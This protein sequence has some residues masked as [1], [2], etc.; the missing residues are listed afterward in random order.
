[1]A[2]IEA[3][4]AEGLRLLRAGEFSDAER[5][6]QRALGS[7]PARAEGWYLLGR[8]R[9]EL[10]KLEEAVQAYRRAVE[11]QPGL[12]EAHNNLGIVLKKLGRIGEALSSYR[13]AVR[14][15]P[16]YVEA[17]NNLGNALAQLDHHDE[18]IECFRHVIQSRPDYAEAHNNLGI[19]F[20]GQG[21]WGEA[22]VSLRQA[23][24]L[25]PDFA[26]AHTNLGI[27]LAERGEHD[28]ALA[29]YRQALA[30]NPRLEEALCGRGCL[31]GR[32]GELEEAEAI[33]REAIRL[34]P[35]SAELWGNHG[36]FLAEQG[37]ISEGLDSYREA[38]RLGPGSATIRSNHLFFL[39]Y[40]PGIDSAT[41]LAEHRHG[42]A[43]LVCCE[44]PESCEGRDRSV[45]RP[46]RVGY[47][48]P[49]LRKHAVASFLEPI[50]AN[51][52]RRRVEAISYADVGSPDAV[53]AR[54]RSL[55]HDWRE[56]RFLSDG[57]LENLIRR[58]R[59]DIL[60]D[61]AGH[62]ARNRLSVF[63]RK[64]APVQVTY[65]GYPTTT[66]LATFD[67]L[68]TDAVVDPP[69]GPA[70]STEEP[71]R[72]PGGSYCYAPPSDAPEV[73]PAPM[74]RAGF[75]TFGSLHKL[76]KLNP[77][78]LDLWSALLR[79]VPSAR[80]LL[81]RDTLKG[82]R[83]D[84]IV[85]NFEA[86]GIVPGR[87]EI[88]HDWRPDEHWATYSSIDVSLDVFPWCGHTTACESLWMGVPIVTLAGLRRSSRMTA[89]VLT[90]MGLTELIA[91]TSEQYIEAASRLV[92]DPN[93]LSR[94][95]GE[96]RQRMQASRLCDGPSFTRELEAAY[97]TLWR[98][99]CNRSR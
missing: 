68:L 8:A 61:L 28:Q 81:I 69:G 95:R 51:H 16:D 38:I 1:M 22:E 85:A 74:L 94:M 25:R 58:D 89:S 65:L 80:L 20:K 87:V 76:P 9:Q 66:G 55:S 45:G 82:R 78:V 84:E 98:R 52:D 92:S 32:R 75:P 34:V 71:L 93:R 23:I 73:A 96:L 24:R 17:R 2:E 72:L 83:R 13:E 56:I 35:D 47:V 49:D 48:S 50:L 41:L 86:N 33:F 88:R 29:C 64:P 54:L 42:V 4:F 31:V 12:A 11:L 7:S 63:A 43:A 60:V 18:A 36:Y 40:D 19:A 15:R 46:L 37:R 59:I 53:T 79:A 77:R 27:V 99:W 30:L 3:A 39:N 90:M 62:T 67:A 6:L 91:E 44:I 26:V 97:E 10:G 57:R 70:Q 5:A 14:R 21:R